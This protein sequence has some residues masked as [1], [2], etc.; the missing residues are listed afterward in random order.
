LSYNGIS[1][2]DYL[3]KMFE[4]IDSKLLRYNMTYT[5]NN[6]SVYEIINMAPQVYYSEHYQE[7]KY[8]GIYRVIQ[9]NIR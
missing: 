9:I 1:N 8:I 2:R 3:A 4:L 6:G 5:D 7:E